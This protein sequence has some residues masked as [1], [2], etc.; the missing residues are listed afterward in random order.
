MLDGGNLLSN[1]QGLLLA[2][3]ALLDENLPHDCDEAKVRAILGEY[4]GGAHVEFL[5]PLVGEPTGHVDVF[6]VFTGAQTVVVGACDPVIDPLN[7][8]IL[9]GNAARLAGL[10]LKNG[11]LR[12]VRVPMPP[13]DDGVWRTHTNVIFANGTLLVPIY[14]GVDPDGERVALDTFAR[15]LPRWD[16]VGIDAS[17]L[18]ECDGALHCISMNVPAQGGRGRAAPRLAASSGSRRSAVPRAASRSL[19]ALAPARP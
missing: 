11:P 2:T 18:I 16:V 6:A 8:Q 5:E 14:P 19:P 13:K 17:A 12:V 10:H 9:D 4:L 15:L 1:G 7:A 3:T